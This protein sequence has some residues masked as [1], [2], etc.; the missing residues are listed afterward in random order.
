MELIILTNKF[1]NMI[2]N[3]T[4]VVKSPTCFSAKMQSSGN[5]KYKGV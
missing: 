2:I 5:L 1:I 4:Q 3:F